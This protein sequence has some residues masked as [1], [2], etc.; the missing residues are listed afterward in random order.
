MF[1]FRWAERERGEALMCR[2]RACAI[3]GWL[4]FPNGLAWIPDMAI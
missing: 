4:D 3:G 1:G 2:A